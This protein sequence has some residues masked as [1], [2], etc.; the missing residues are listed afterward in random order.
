MIV[1]KNEAIYKYQQHGGKN[2]PQFTM[3]G[4]SLYGRICDVYD[5]DTVTLILEVDGTYRK[6]KAR[7]NGIDTCELKSK[8]SKNREL[9]HKA[10]S[11]LIELITDSHN[12]STTMYPNKKDTKQL[13][14][15]NVY[16]VWVKCYEFDKYGRVLVDLFLDE[17]CTKSFSEILNE[18][19]LAYVYQGD[20]KLTEEQQVQALVE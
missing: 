17:D 16:V 1:S 19:H 13:F 8:S 9:A 14:E 15:D 20:T 7:L 12:T 3:N 10:R 5:G 11:R 4:V 6:F 2:T 18:E